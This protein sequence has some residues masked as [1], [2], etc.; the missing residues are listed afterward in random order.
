VLHTP[1]TGVGVGLVLQFAVAPPLRPLHDQV[2]R[3]DPVTI[4]GEPTV[5]RLFTGTDARVCPFDIPHTHATGVGTTG[6]VPLQV[7]LHFPG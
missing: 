7:I 5:Q 4:D 2:H 6:T 3:P 1:G